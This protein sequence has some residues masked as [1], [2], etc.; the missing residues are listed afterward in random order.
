MMR[1][2]SLV[3]LV[4]SLSLTLAAA[5]EP[6]I[7]LHSAKVF[8]GDPARPTAQAVAIEGNRIAAVGTNEEIRRLAGPKTQVIDAGGRV[9]IPG[10]NDAH[11]HAGWAVSVFGIDRG[12]DPSRADIE[13]AIANAIDETPSDL[14]IVATIGPTI[15]MDPNVNGDSLEKTARGRK[16]MLSSF[17]GHGAILSTSAMKALGVAADAKDPRGGWYGRDA[18]GRLDGRVFE[19]AQYPLHRA[20]ADMAS[21]DELT[22][23]VRAMSEEALALGITSVQVMPSGKE[24]R[25]A[26]VVAREKIPLRVRVIDFLDHGD[27]RADAV[28]WILDGT[29]VEGGAALRTA[30]Y[31]AGGQGRENFED[32]APIAKAAADAKKQLLV[33]AVGD[34]T[35]E[36]ALKA[37]AKFPTLQR[38]RIEHGDGL[39]SDLFPLAVRTGTIVV[40]NPAHFMFRDRFPKGEYAL[41][42]SIQKAGIPIAIGSDGPINPYLNILWATN[43]PDLPAEAL[44][45]EEAVRAYTSGSA[46]AEMREK[47]KG[48]IAPGMLADL[49]V[50][51]QDIFTVPAAKLPETVSVLTIVDGKVAHSSM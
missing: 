27:V 37:F 2:V 29:P 23:N 40:Q 13:A 44:T 15:L 16:V 3:S 10:I 21:D 7:V 49:A 31:P 12:L 24:Q 41:F 5:A 8:T 32:L 51:S 19:Y 28:K 14:W 46:Y 38:P 20:I 25:F 18:G 6:T 33:H 22:T 36:D 17:T 42:K 35:V 34:R 43:R 1:R 39:Q 48:T 45:R 26:D 9:V 30:K 50:L 4:V 11:V 47:E